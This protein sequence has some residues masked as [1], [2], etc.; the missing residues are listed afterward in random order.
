MES[1][2]GSM[3]FDFEGVYTNIITNKLIEYVIAD[4]RNIKIEFIDKG[5]AIKIVESFDAEQDNS[6]AVQQ[7]GWQAILNNFKKYIESN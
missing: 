2:D 3:G 6:V 1:K 7:A 4:G 5:N